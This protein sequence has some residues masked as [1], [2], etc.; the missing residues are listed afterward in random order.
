MLAH[1][2]IQRQLII[3][4]FYFSAAMIFY[5]DALFIH[6]VEILANRFGCDL[7]LLRQ[8]TY[9]CASL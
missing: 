2:H 8:F 3:G 5:D 4:V 6:T 1:F 9:T 7:Q